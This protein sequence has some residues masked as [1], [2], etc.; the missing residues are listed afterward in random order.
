MN[1]ANQL[2]EKRTELCTI[3]KMLH[4]IANGNTNEEDKYEISDV[5][6]SI[7]EIIIKDLKDMKIIEEEIKENG[8]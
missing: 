2:E 3:A 4:K 8:N 1:S 7:I 6:V 5:L